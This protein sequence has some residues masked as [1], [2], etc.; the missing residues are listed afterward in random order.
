MMTLLLLATEKCKNRVSTSNDHLSTIRRA[1]SFIG[2][3]HSPEEF[4]CVEAFGYAAFGGV[5][6]GCAPRPVSFE[7]CPTEDIKASEILPTADGAILMLFY[8][9]SGGRENQ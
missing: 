8:D 6:R 3:C 7:P 1:Y 9:N 4:L 2:A 5:V